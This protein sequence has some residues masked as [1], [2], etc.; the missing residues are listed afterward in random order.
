MRI[1]EANNELAEILFKNEFGD[2]TI[3]RDKKKGKKSFQLYKNSKKK[4]YFD[5]INIEIINSPEVLDTKYNLTEDQLK[6]VLMYFK[7]NAADFKE[8]VGPLGFQILD[9]EKRLNEIKAELKAL[10]EF[11]CKLQK[12]KKLNK[13]LDFY[14]NIK[15]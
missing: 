12:Q 13:I 2:F 15:I 14:N 4:I 3:E 10:Q 6:I 8:L 9:A 5:Y 7:L 1:F 11:N